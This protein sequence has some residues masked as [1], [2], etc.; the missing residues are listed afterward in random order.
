MKMHMNLAGCKGQ[1]KFV[2]PVGQFVYLL[3]KVKSTHESIKC[4]KQTRG[5]GNRKITGREFLN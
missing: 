3:G 5:T 4:P 2:Y 1:N